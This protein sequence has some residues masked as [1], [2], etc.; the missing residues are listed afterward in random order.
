MQNAPDQTPTT[1]SHK[2]KRGQP[3]PAPTREPTPPK[4]KGPG[5]NTCSPEPLSDDETKT[6]KICEAAVR[7]YESASLQ[8]GYA[9]GTI[10][11]ADLFRETHA[12]F[13][14][15]VKA[16]YSFTVR[17]AEQLIAG[18]DTV[19]KMA[20]EGHDVLPT[21][22]GQ[23]RALAGLSRDE[24]WRAWKDAIKAPSGPSAKKVHRAVKALFT[25]PEST[26]DWSK[27]AREALKDVAKDHRADVT[28]AVNSFGEDV[29][30]AMVKDVAE[31]HRAA[32]L[33]DGDDRGERSVVGEAKRMVEAQE[34]GIEVPTGNSNSP[35]LDLDILDA[36][37]LTI[38][39]KRH[40]IAVLTDEKRP[41]LV[42]LPSGLA[43]RS[44][45]DLAPTD[46]SQIIVEIAELERLGGPVRKGK[47]I[48]DE[49]RAF[50]DANG[51]RAKMQRTKVHV[52]WARYTSSSLTGCWHGCRHEFCYAAGIARRLF[53]QGFLPTLYPARLDHLRNET[54]RDVSELDREEAWRERSVFMV[55]MG[56]LFGGWVP[57]WYVEAV[58]E[59]VRSNPGWFCFFLTKHPKGLDR[60]TFPPNSAVGLTLTGDEPYGTGAYNEEQRVRAYAEYADQLGRV[61]GAAFTWLSIEPFRGD[62]G[63]LS[64]FFDAGVQM[65][66]IG[67]QSATT[68]LGRDGGLVHSPA[69]QPELPWV[70]S[71]R[72]Q[73]RAAG[74]MLFEKENLVVRPKEIPF[75]VG[76][77]GPSPRS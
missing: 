36:N 64:P 63:D 19:A 13:S 61:K 33:E 31:G 42:A 65:V 32:I 24:R 46:A 77:P 10:K 22:E 41:L 27:E 14:A 28:A 37:G 17:R 3:K 59:E 29:T 55:A 23:A 60:F 26:D 44:L 7:E 49:V 40:S 43:P 9:L 75:P 73:V 57:A 25:S 48:L 45:R 56:D 71:V 38:T 67:G 53:A 4:R 76:M 12:S 16:T 5:A 34:A 21:N 2:A 35:I 11:A 74:V 68:L 30:A 51:I 54:L 58:L 6:L 18:A 52:D 47:L 20:T 50:C 70:D 62:V 8:A 39:A 72:R 15:Y 66:A 1:R 69:R